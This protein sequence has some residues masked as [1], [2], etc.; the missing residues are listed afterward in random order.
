MRHFLTQTTLGQ[1]GVTS[2]RKRSDAD[3]RRCLD[4]AANGAQ[5][6]FGE[7]RTSAAF[8]QTSF[9]SL[10]SIEV[11]GARVENGEAHSAGATAVRVA[12]DARAAV[13]ATVLPRRRAHQVSITEQVYA[14]L[15]HPSGRVRIVCLGPHN[16]RRGNGS[17]C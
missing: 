10:A 6:V 7:R 5:R 1:L 4:R 12:R 16:R 17:I 3:E 15:L 8:L 11:K 13:G 9:F 2:I 14:G